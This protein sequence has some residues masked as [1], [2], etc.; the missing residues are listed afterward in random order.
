MSNKAEKMAAAALALTLKSPAG[1]GSGVTTDP[2]PTE[3]STYPVQSGGV[4]TELQKKAN[5]D[6]AYE[7]LTAG[8]AE[9]IVSSVYVTDKAPYNFRTSGGNADIGNRE[10]DT[11]V[12]GTIVW[13]Q[14]VGAADVS[15]TVPSGHKYV[16]FIGGEWT[17]NASSGSAVTVDGSGGDMVFDITLMFGSAVANHVYSLEQATSGAGAAWFRKLFPK[18]GYAYNAGE[19]LSVNVSSHDTVGFNAYDHTGGTARL[20][21]GME[22]QITGAYTSLSYEDVNGNAETITP[23][24][25]GTFTPANN[26]TLTVAG[27]NAA[28]TCVHLTWS[29]Y[30]NGEFEEYVKRTYPLDGSLTLC[31]IPKLDGSN[32]LCFDGDT[33]ASDGTVTRK[34]R[35]V[36]LGTLTWEKNNDGCFTTNSLNSSA[37][38]GANTIPLCTE[39]TGGAPSLNNSRAFSNGNM[40]I[41][42]RYPTFDRMYVRD[43]GRYGSASANEFKQA[44]NG[45]YLIYELLNPSTESAEP[46]TNPQIVDDFG[47]EEYVDHACSQGTRD[48]AVPAG[49][50]TRYQNNLRDKLQRL[51]NIPDGN[52]DYLVRYSN[53]QCSFAAYSAPIGIPSA[54]DAEGT[55]ILK[56]TV[57]EGE[58]AYT[59][60]A[61][62]DNAE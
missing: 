57:S 27:G 49:H 10:S 12:G 18:T 5:T 61:V 3:G 25:D 40:T 32:E 13:N 59:W 43:D 20:I 8:N 44:M 9:Q 28:T 21:G 15:V 51:P 7:G 11:V 6:G 60:E 54:P 56:A 23:G 34:Y 17:V 16:A 39:Y 24:S 29:G 35:I 45:V 14:S 2:T 4:Y 22:Y 52:G 31:G 1:G 53:R 41:C 58:T 37:R 26:G 62:N 38:V 47:T 48:V 33:Y 30:R 36:D 19:M 50:V 55:Y 42:F 46:F